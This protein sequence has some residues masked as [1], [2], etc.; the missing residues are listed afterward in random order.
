MRV[1]LSIASRDLCQSAVF[2]LARGTALVLP[3]AG[4]ASRLRTAGSLF[5]ARGP[6]ANRTSSLIKCAA[7]LGRATAGAD[8]AAC[9]C[10]SACLRSWQCRLA[11]SSDTCMNNKLVCDAKTNADATCTS[12]GTI[13]SH[14]I[15]LGPL[16]CL[17]IL[18][19]SIMVVKGWPVRAH[20]QTLLSV[21]GH[22]HCVLHWRAAG[23]AV[24]ST[25]ML[26]SRVVSEAALS[27][28]PRGC[29]AMLGLFRATFC[30]ICWSQHCVGSSTRMLQRFTACASC[31]RLSKQ[32]LF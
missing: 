31:R 9:I 20:L 2:T 32:A 3:A 14:Q 21:V 27:V 13:C 19:C 1:S 30:R 25:S 26:S 12:L 28:K 24:A 7:V 5:Y 22:C 15:K 29:L 23:C 16:A 4:A 11:W 18:A 17:S 10:L 6:D 8:A